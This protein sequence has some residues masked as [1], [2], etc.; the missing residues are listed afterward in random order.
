M[1]SQP[2]F[3]PSPSPPRP[4]ND[5]PLSEQNSGKSG[6]LCLW[7]CHLL[8]LLTSKYPLKKEGEIGKGRMI[9]GGITLYCDAPKPGCPLTTRQP[10]EYSWMSGNPTPLM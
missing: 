9:G 3:T 1:I 10:A 7:I 2:F 5:Y 4:P 6:T 8:D